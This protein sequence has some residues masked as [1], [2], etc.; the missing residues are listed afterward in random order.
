T[1]VP[2]PP[3]SDAKASAEFFLITPDAVQGLRT[4]AD[5][6]FDHEHAYKERTSRKILS[7]SSLCD[8]SVR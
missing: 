4:Y 8:P 1:A 5:A 2:T 6:P 3:A 7:L